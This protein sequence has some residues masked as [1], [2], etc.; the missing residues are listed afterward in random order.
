MTTRFSPGAGSGSVPMAWIEPPEAVVAT[1]LVEGH[2]VANV[3]RP[4]LIR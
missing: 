4:N 2:D 1:D 3:D